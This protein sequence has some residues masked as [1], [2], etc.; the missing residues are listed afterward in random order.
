[1]SPCDQMGEADQA[2]FETDFPHESGT[3][4]KAAEVVRD[5]L[6]HLDPVVRQKVLWGNVIC[7]FGLSC[8]QKGPCA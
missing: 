5:E 4:P 7:L 6:E 8:R 2:L 1:M 3:W